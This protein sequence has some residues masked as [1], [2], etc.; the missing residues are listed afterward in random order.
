M[1]ADTLI[2]IVS[3]ATPLLAF[4]ASYLSHMIYQKLP[5]QDQAAVKQ[6]ADLVVPAVEQS[7]SL[8]SGAGKK[9]E[10]LRIATSIMN[11]LGIK[12]NATLLESAIEAA[13]YAMNQQRQTSITVMRPAVPVATSPS[14]PASAPTP[15]TTK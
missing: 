13:V 8:L 14:S 9:Q 7:A 15:P 1:N 3:L 11:A 4:L 5:T 6:I 10:A 2:T 12:M